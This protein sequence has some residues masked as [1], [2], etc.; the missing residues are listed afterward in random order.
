MH[1]CRIIKE[2]YDSL[3][4]IVCTVHVFYYVSVWARKNGYVLIAD[5]LVANKSYKTIHSLLKLYN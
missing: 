5:Y 4:L 3:S 2:V 1:A